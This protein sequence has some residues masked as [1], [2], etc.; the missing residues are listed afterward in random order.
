MSTR[1][2]FIKTGSVVSMAALIPG[3]AGRVF[4]RDP[5][6]TFEIPAGIGLKSSNLFTGDAYRPFV[7][8]IFEFSNTDSRIRRRLKLVEVKDS[9]FKSQSWFGP[10]V[11]GCSLLFE[12][13]GKT[14]HPQDVYRMHHAK[15]GDLDVLLVPVSNSEDLYEVTFAQI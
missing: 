5:E 4:A 12:G 15:I 2:D 10:K 6:A 13:S 8:G 11:K 3:M 14:T 7:N 1:R 9:V